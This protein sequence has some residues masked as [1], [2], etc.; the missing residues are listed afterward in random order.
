[1]HGFIPFDASSCHREN[2]GIATSGYRVGPTVGGHDE[3]GTLWLRRFE[4]VGQIV[5]A[6]GKNVP[7]WKGPRDSLRWKAL[8]GG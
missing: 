2:T 3:Y 4:Q 5:S 6:L 8:R 7:L 1:M